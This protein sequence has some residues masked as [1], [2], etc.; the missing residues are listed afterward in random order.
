MTPAEAAEVLRRHSPALGPAEAH[1]KSSLEGAVN[2][3]GKL[4]R[5]RLVH[6]G[7]MAHGFDPEGAE[8]LACAV[9]YFHLASLLFDDLPCMD[10][11]D[12][13]RGRPTAHRVHGE[14]TAILA[15]L[16]LI[17]RAYALAGFA[18]ALQPA[19]VRMQSHACLD[20]CLGVAGLVGGQARDLRFAE[21]DR[22][23]ATVSRIAAAKTGALFWLAVYLPALPGGPGP[24]ERQG[25]K[26]LCVYWGLV[27][28]VIDDVQDALATEVEAGKPTR[29]DREL[30]RPNL[31]VAL[32]LPA[33]TRRI[34][35]L[36]A[37][38]ERTVT[39]LEREGGARWSYL[40]EFHHENFVANRAAIAAA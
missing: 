20:A 18:L 13:R 33:A 8:Q 24:R 31:V 9:E 23:P 4:V 10:N 21:S 2:H 28:Q 15:G 30:A 25:L 35:R 32:G 37:Q 19:A 5:A 3:P 14:A 11:A 6:R 1:L 34:A 29:R 12:T 7:L 27:F 39:A 40:R 22:T 16:A 17:N 38:A 26:A 36:L